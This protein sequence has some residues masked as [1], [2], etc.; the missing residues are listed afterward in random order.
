MANHPTYDELKK[1]LKQRTDQLRE[2]TALLIQKEKDFSQAIKVLKYERDLSI[3]LSTIYNLDEGLQLSL[4]AGLHVSGMDCGGIYLFD[5]SSGNLHLQ[6][7][8]GLSAEFVR[9]VAHFSNDS[10]HT[11]FVRRGKPVYTQ[12]EDLGV[13][14]SP[15]VRREGLKAFITVP[16]RNEDTVVGCLNLGSHKATKVPPNAIIPVETIAAQIEN[17]L[18]LLKTKEKLY[19]SE[20]HLESFKESAT[21]FAVYRLAHD[22]SSPH[23]LRVAFVSNSAKDILGIEDPI[24]FETW[25]ENMHPD[26]VDR[27]VRAN[28]RA[29]KT[30]HF[31]EEYRTFNHKFDEYHWIHVVSTGTSNENGW[32]GFVNGI[33]IDV[34]EKYKYQEE[35][36]RSEAHLKSLMDS[37]SGFVVYRMVRDDSEPNNLKMAAVS[38]SVY[39]IL[40]Y[41]PEDFEV[42]SYY[43]NVHPED[44]EGVMKAHNAAFETGKFERTA[45][46]YNPKIGEFVWIHA[47]SL[48]VKDKNGEITHVNGIFIDV[49]EKYDAFWKLKS[50][51]KELENKTKNLMELNAALNV[52]IKNLESKES[53]IQEQVIANVQQLVLPY[54]DKIRANPDD[55]STESLVDIVES[56]LAAITAKFTHR[57]S[58]SLYCLT[59]TEIK[60]ANLIKLGN[61]TKDIATAL[62]ISYKTVESHRERI[63]KK[64]GINNRKINLRSRLL[65]MQ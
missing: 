7:A 43:D 17:T 47:I 59:S 41:K 31:N 29:F 13:P 60:V 8:K 52:L 16:L 50:S 61:T 11:V 44:A 65:S 34:T 19:E 36:K 33:M 38:P 32:T 63:R 48:A 49:S 45:R 2:A 6:V 23:K 18:S 21:N 62:G 9:E 28:Q 39:E 57:L 3:S 46:V 25:F 64:L 5:E 37:A 27:V 35:L 12:L 14:S 15:A 10:E 53:D 54:L 40:G 26:D 30:G 24:K 42:S 58:S 20:Q 4:E 51:E 55:I 56:N 22:E 1:L